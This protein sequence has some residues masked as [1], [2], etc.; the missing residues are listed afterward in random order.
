MATNVSP[1]KGTDILTS[2]ATPLYEPLYHIVDFA[3][4]KGDLRA[5]TTG[6]PLVKH[7]VSAT[8]TPSYNNSVGCN[9][10][11]M[12]FGEFAALITILVMV[13]YISLTYY[14]YHYY[15]L[16][17]RDD[18]NLVTTTGVMDFPLRVVS[19]GGEESL[20][21][22]LCSRVLQT[23]WL[24][25]MNLKCKCVS[26]LKC[27]DINHK[28][29]TTENKSND[30]AIAVSDNDRTWMKDHG[31]QHIAVIMDGNRRYGKSL[32]KEKA[33]FVAKEFHKELED[34]N[35]KGFRRG[36]SC[37]PGDSSRSEGLKSYLSSAARI[38][39]SL[40]DPSAS[41]LVG[42]DTNTTSVI[43]C[44]P[45]I[46]NTA[47]QYLGHKAGG[48]KLL[49]FI[50]YC[51]R[52]NIPLLS[53]YAFSSENWSRSAQE[54]DMLMSLFIIYFEKM[55]IEAHK[56]GIFIRFV[57]TDFTRIPH[58][59]R[60][61]MREIEE[62]TALIR[63][64][65][66]VVNVMVSYGSRDEILNACTRII[67]SRGLESVNGSAGISST[68]GAKHQC[69]S[70]T[71]N[72]QEGHAFSQ[73]SAFSDV[74][75]E[76]FKYYLTRSITSMYPISS[77]S[78][79]EA[80]I[81]KNRPHGTSSINNTVSPDPDILFRTGGDQRL[82][83]F[84]MYQCAYSEIYFCKKAWPEVTEADVGD[85]VYDFVFNRKRRFGR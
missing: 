29:K 77:L 44:S 22:C 71:F 62:E 28:S 20:L 81:N 17:R 1:Q 7:G 41:Y 23:M 84:M 8:F 13:G 9:A 75:D 59:V 82:S 5:L 25:F 85:M 32:D 63:P 40:L 60:E 67:I 19:K 4:A 47:R 78:N 65:V 68:T 6:T 15:F 39:A 27:G 36:D 61:L 51:I 33:S 49:Q 74:T 43:L 72:G 48:E 83:N 50:Q 57:A 21:F 58:P 53:V 54:I 79:S 64:R 46:V 24:D 34:S 70:L 38:L 66:I 35:N 52:W 10:M 69:N 2:I 26:L 56:T 18:N 42:G 11:M 45:E 14:Y 16:E 80:E 31:I 3:F 30:S 73:C 76:E 37:S 12:F 55:R